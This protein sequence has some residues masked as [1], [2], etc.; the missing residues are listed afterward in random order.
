MAEGELKNFYRD[1]EFW[2]ESMVDLAN[3]M[4]T[5][6]EVKD[7]FQE[8]FQKLDDK[9]LENELLKIAKKRKFE[10]KEDEYED[11]YKFRQ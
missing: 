9:E 5:E 8:Y 6:D 1:Q 10:V 4:L 3:D 2:W 11:L 7:F